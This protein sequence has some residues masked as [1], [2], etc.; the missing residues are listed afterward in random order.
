M[1]EKSSTLDDKI[2]QRDD[3]ETN[4]TEQEQQY[5]KSHPYLYPRWTK[6]C[7]IGVMSFGEF[8]V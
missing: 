2:C 6:F 7:C 4:V 5:D 3:V 1:S 8:I